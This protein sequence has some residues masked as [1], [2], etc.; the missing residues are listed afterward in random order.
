MNLK[1]VVLPALVVLAVVSVVTWAA[2]SPDPQAVPLSFAA[3]SDD[4][5]DSVAKV[6]RLFENVWEDK[7]LVPAGRASELQILRRMS[8]ALHGT[9]PS[10]EELRQFE[11][12]TRP[13]RLRHWTV[14][15]L[16]DNRFADYF[17]ERLSRCFVGT[18]E[19]QFVLFRRD[20]FNDWLIEQLR[21]KRPYDATVRSMIAEQGLWTDS[22]ASNFATAAVVEGDVDEN[23]LAGRV[24]RAFLGQRMDCA[25]CHDHPFDDWTQQQY[26][27][28]A[29]QFAHVRASLVGMEDKQISDGESVEYV[30][31][32]RETLEDRVVPPSVPFHP[33]W[34]P[35]AGTRR[36]Q[37]AA[38]VTHPENR[39]F[40]R[41]TANRVWGL[42]FGKPYYEP[43]D[44]L[45]DPPKDEE[46]GL[47]DVLGADFREHGYDLHHL[48]RVIV[49]SRP[50]QVDSAHPTVADEAE[51]DRLSEQWALFPMTRLRPEQVIGAILQS[52]SIRT[53][54]RNSHLI[55]R[56]IRFIRENDF[57]EEYGDLGEDELLQRPGTIPQALL[58]MNGELPNELLEANPFNASGR[59]ATF[60]GTDEKCLDTCYLVCLTRRPSPAERDYFVAQLEETSGDQRTA[61]IEDMLW[62]IFNT[63]E[64]SCNH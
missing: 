19:G 6:D 52:G 22:P 28:I 37:L 16:A 61:V 33:E 62:S 44:D 56:F 46:P 41:A 38:W 59:I 21:E 18:D 43:V 23:K 7:E 34:L 3:P 58:Q 26:E 48:I 5:A 13:D 17:A 4:V 49:A 30:I 47:L 64:F 14:R 42:L 24:V 9:V 54:D 29:A 35:D 53:I 40:E 45:P 60:A 32:D 39:R 11:S 12:D 1:T 27:G 57:V 36:E 10:L 15:L 50:F 31:E 2:R 55:V 51:L 63:R 25:Q 8:L 20:R